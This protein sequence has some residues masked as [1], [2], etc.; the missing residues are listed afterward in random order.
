MKR[1][2]LCVLLLFGISLLSLAETL[3]VKQFRHSGPYPVRTP[4]LIDTVNVKSEPIQAVSACGRIS[5]DFENSRFAPVTV[6]IEGAVKEHQLFV[7]GKAAGGTLKLDPGTHRVEIKYLLEDGEKPSLDVSLETPEEGILSLRED[8]RHRYGMKD[9]LLGTRVAGVALSPDGRWLITS[10][11]TTREGGRT[12]RFCTVSETA[13]GRVLTRTGERLNWMPRSGKYYFTRKEVPGTRLLAVDPA[14]GQEEILAEDIPEGPFQFSPAEDALF[15]M[16]HEDGPAEREN[17]YQILSPDDRQ[18]GWRSRAYPARYDLATGVMQRLA[19]GYHNVWLSDISQDGAKALLL[20]SEERLEKRPTTVYT[21]Y[22]M[23]LASLKAEKLVDR[24]GFMQSAA[25]S[26]DGRQVLL[27]GSPEAFGGIGM[28]VHKGQTPSMTDIQ[29]YLMDLATRKIRPLTRDFDPCVSASAWSLADGQ[30]YLTAENRDRIDL[31]R[32]DPRSGRIRQ[33]ETPEDLVK[34]FSLASQAPAMAWY[35]QGASNSDRV[36]L[37]DTRSGKSTLRE[38]LS[39]E[40]LR[41]VVLGECRAW[42]F[43]NSKGETVYGRFYL[44]PD[45]DPSKKYPMI[46]NYYGGCSPTSRNFESRY[47]HHAYAALGY[48][49][50]VVALPSGATGNGQA[51]SARH[52][53][54]AGDGPAQDII[55]G[56]EQFC[57]EHPF[58]NPERIGCIGASY[59]GFMS[60]YIPTLTDRFACAISHAGISDHTSYWGFGYWGYSYSETSMA[61]SYPCSTWPTR[62]TPRSSSS[63]ATPTPTSPSTRASR[64]SRPSNCWARRPPSLPSRTRTTTSSTTPNVSTG[65]TPSGP[66]SPNTSRTTPPGGTP[67]IRRRHYNSAAMLLTSSI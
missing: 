26:P 42:N 22:L 15:Y 33:V 4:L 56:T 16:M 30:I 58:V 36:Y 11:T 63:T 13:T 64:C 2:S 9:V 19:Y 57:R 49:V 18:P 50:Y 5:F 52:V 60:Q 65:R 24:D 43:K 54:T 61:N 27:S 44:P 34:G 46:V 55:E 67:S 66:G 6:H 14:T 28:N 25:F 59:G 48:V 35:G 47:P 21:L 53:N 38:D 7:D 45:F 62:S 17:I 29:L 3:S 1:L 39:A 10:Y 51:W 20:V 40:I 31:F 12:E 37:A 32:I 23:D 41:D 8:G